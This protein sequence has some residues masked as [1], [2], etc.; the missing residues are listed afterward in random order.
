MIR[1][2]A[3]LLSGIALAAQAGAG[4]D[5][6]TVP[7]DP[8]VLEARLVEGI[9]LVAAIA[10]A[11]EYAGGKASSARVDAETA[12]ATVTV[13]RSDGTN[14][15]VTVDLD[16][17][18]IMNS[19]SRNRFP[20]D[21][22]QG[23]ATIT[24]SGLMYYDL[25]AGDGDQPA[26]SSAMVEVHYTGWLTDGTKFDSSH[27]RG[28]TITFGLNQVI[29]GWTEGLQSMKVGGKRKLVIPPELGYGA[30]GAPPQIPADATLVF[31]VEL[32][33]LP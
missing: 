29:S 18:E 14:L 32:V 11:E 25:H 1:T 2:I 21:P 12:Q 16:E 33:S 4:I 9:G 26:G 3:V 24:P 28:E 7:P 30:A 5:Y 23:D 19:E 20:G 31:D 13:A 8:A 15:I 17:G 22:A 6:R 10:R 27:D